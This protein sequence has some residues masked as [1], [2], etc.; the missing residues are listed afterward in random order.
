MVK[1]MTAIAM[2]SSI[3][4]DALVLGFVPESF[5]VVAFGSAHHSL[6]VVLAP[7]RRRP[8]RRGLFSFVA[9]GSSDASK[10]R[11]IYQFGLQ[12]RPHGPVRHPGGQL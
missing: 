8:M 3:A 10:N 12:T 2:D 11:P 1:S 5:A 6:V 4:I 7:R 9:D